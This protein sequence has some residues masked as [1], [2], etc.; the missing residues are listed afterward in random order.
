M[1][2]PARRWSVRTGACGLGLLPVLALV[3]H[4]AAA[5]R[6]TTAASTGSTKTGDRLVHYVVLGLAGALLLGLVGI[7]GLY[8]TRRRP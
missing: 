1:S 8:L 4:A 5:V 2:S 6:I 3:P 7:V